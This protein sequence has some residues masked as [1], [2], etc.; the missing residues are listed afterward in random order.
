MTVQHLKDT[1]NRTP[2]VPFRIYYPGGP[3]VDV[4]YRDAASMSPT[5]RILSVYLP[6]E[7]QIHLDVAL[8][9]STENLELTVH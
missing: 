1:L 8:I 2:F 7:R 4:P 5:G 6:D 3:A 9:T